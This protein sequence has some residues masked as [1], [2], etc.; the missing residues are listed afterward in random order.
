MPFSVL[1][2][3]I[4]IQN[5]LLRHILLFNAFDVYIMKKLYSV[6]TKLIQLFILFY[7]EKLCKQ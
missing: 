5:L 1:H 3:Y 7:L 6:F 4:V 2:L